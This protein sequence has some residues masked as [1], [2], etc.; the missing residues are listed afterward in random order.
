MVV[1]DVSL[2]GGL[3]ANLVILVVVLVQL[4][5]HLGISS[6]IIFPLLEFS[7]FHVQTEIKKFHYYTRV[8][9][10]SFI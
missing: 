4:L 8:A 7:I 5:K 1:L 3:E 9:D 6:H 2:D 10:M